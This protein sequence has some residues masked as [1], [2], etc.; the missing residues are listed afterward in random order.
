[1]AELVISPDTVGVTVM[2]MFWVAPLGK[3]GRAHVSCVPDR[4]QLTLALT[5]VT[6]LGSV[7]TSDT[8]VAALGP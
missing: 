6:P 4:L 8:T 5:N 2:V 7:S 1:M 3:S